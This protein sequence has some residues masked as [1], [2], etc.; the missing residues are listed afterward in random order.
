MGGREL[1]NAVE[2]GVGGWDVAECAVQGRRGGAHAARL[3]GVGEQR[4][5]LRREPQLAVDLG[6]KERLFAGAV[7]RQHQPT[8]PV[9]PHRQ[10]EHSFEPT[11]AVRAEALIQRNDRLDITR[12]AERITGEGILAAQLGRVVDLAV[13]DHPD[14]RI[15]ALERLVAGGQVHDGEPAGAQARALVTHD[16]LSVGPPVGERGGH[17]GHAVGMLERGAR[18]R[19]GAEDAAHYRTPPPR[20]GGWGGWGGGGGRHGPYAA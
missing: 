1:R 7:A 19:D 12:R 10:A 6:P 15:G 11:H 3:V 18:E 13:A 16:A 20:R 14:G 8:V 9:V 5:N 4:L 2:H 17:G